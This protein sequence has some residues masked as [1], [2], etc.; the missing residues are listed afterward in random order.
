[1]ETPKRPEI[2]DIQRQMLRHALGLDQSKNAYRNHYVCGSVA[3][4]DLWLDAHAK[5]LAT[6]GG[7]LTWHVTR[8]GFAEVA[9]PGETFD[10]ET[11]AG[12]DRLVAERATRGSDWVG[13]PGHDAR[14]KAI[15]ARKAKEK[16]GRD[17]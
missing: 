14:V 3:G 11:F 4:E 9:L 17:D 13:T 2:T 16:T 12:V 5:G 10:H 6:P 7:M 15:K 1:M 8:A